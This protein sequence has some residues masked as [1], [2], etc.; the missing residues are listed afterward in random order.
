MKPFLLMAGANYYPE[1]GVSDWIDCYETAEEARAQ[2]TR[3]D[4]RQTITSGKN[5]GQ[6]VLS[7]HYEIAGR[8]GI[9]DWYEIEDL[10]SWM[11]KS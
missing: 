6:D 8:T 4:D 1:G 9:Y 3:I 5:K 11:N 10:R 2:I 7:H